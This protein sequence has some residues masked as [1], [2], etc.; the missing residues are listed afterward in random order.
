MEPQKLTIANLD[1]GGLNE[2]V[3]RELGRICES[4]ADSNVKAEAV[5][6]LTIK[7]KI[8][9]NTKKNM[10]AIA[11]QVKSEIPSVDPGTT[12][13]YI[14]MDAGELCFYP[15]DVRQQT[16]PMEPMVTE[17][18]AVSAPSVA[19]GPTPVAIAPPRTEN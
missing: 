4:I 19:P 7:V 6:T 11:Y 13:A 1:N 12:Q 14:A 18:R 16:L 3:E 2:L 10:A 5:R 15:A 9:P 8:K 17:I